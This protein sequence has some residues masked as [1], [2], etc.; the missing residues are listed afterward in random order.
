M[1]FDS[2]ILSIKS[3]LVVLEMINKSGA[4]HIGS[5]F[6]ISDLIAVIYNEFVFPHNIKRNS[7]RLLALC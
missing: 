1:A 4:S 7:C 6:S 3:R 2:Q 5:A